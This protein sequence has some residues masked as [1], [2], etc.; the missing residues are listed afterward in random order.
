VN[1]HGL[2]LTCQVLVRA[3]DHLVRRFQTRGR[4]LGSGPTFQ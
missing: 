4:W 2:A 3:Q 1:E